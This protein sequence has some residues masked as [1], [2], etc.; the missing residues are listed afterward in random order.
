MDQRLT[1]APVTVLFLDVEGS[2]ALHSARGDDEAHAIVASCEE[3]ARRQVQAHG[4]RTVKSLGDGLMA[5]F[6]SPRRAVACA[7]AIQEAMAE[8]AHW[9][10]EDRVRVRVGLHTGE[11]I[12]ASGDLY[13]NAV[14]AAARIC[15]RARAGEVLISEVVRQLCGSVSASVFEDRGRVSLKGFPQRWRLYRVAPGHAPHR[16]SRGAQTPF[17]GRVAEKSRLRRLMDAVLA[18]TGALVMVGG[19]PGVG[20]TRFEPGGR[21]RGA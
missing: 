13:G 3:R 8:E 6:T 9:R 12:E 11:V 18:G 2:T 21:A 1:E 20:K 15:A 17:V 16:L 14:N 19:E 7:L 4:G 5:A 10:L